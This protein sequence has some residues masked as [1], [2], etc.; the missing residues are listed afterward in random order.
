MKQTFGVLGHQI[1]V[2]SPAHTD[3]DSSGRRDAFWL[4]SP[5][6]S[7]IWGVGVRFKASTQQKWEDP[8]LSSRGDILPTWWYMPEIPATQTQMGGELNSGDAARRLGVQ[9]LVS[10]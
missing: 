8:Q 9:D 3:P 10:K 6:T 5:P 4:P 2:P 7:L 1:P